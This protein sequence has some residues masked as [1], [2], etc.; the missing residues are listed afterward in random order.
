MLGIKLFKQ[1]NN[2]YIEIM[3]D[4]VGITNDKIKAILKNKVEHIDVSKFKEVGL[5]NVNRRIKLICGTEY[6]ID[7]E[8]KVS[9]YTNVIVK[10]PIE[11]V[12][13]YKQ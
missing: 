10:L 3:D 7:I 5:A 2:I 13:L 8:S 4:G 1:Q 11:D 6:G 12:K 9:E